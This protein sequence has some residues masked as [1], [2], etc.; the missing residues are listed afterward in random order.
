MSVFNDVVFAIEN[1]WVIRFNY[2]GCPRVVE[3]YLLG[4]TTKG[5]VALRGYQ[6]EG[7]SRNG[8]VPGWRLFQLSMI[9]AITVERYRFG[10]ARPLYNPSD[11]AMRRTFARV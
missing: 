9:A 6:T 5:T 10:G 1:R 8:K 3:P 11:T 4:E 2:D 7:T